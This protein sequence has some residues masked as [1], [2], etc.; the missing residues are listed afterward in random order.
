MVFC[1]TFLQVMMVDLILCHL[2]LLIFVEWIDGC[3]INL[4]NLNC[5]N[6]LFSP[7]D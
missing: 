7:F 4:V 2:K 5:V 1:G 6:E 3:L